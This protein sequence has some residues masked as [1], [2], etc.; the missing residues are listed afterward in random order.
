MAMLRWLLTADKLLLL[1]HESDEELWIL[2]GGAICMLR[3]TEIADVI[4]ILDNKAYG[5]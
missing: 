2:D 4:A 1:G 3:I 5:G